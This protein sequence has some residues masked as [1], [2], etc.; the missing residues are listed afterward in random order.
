MDWLV[1][2]MSLP[3]RMMAQMGSATRVLHLTP[4]EYDRVMAMIGPKDD[5]IA[6]LLNNINLVLAGDLAPE[7][8]K[9]DLHHLLRLATVIGKVAETDPR[10]GLLLLSRF[11]RAWLD[12]DYINQGSLVNEGCAGR[13]LSRI[14][15]NTHAENT[16][17][18]PVT[19]EAEAKADRPR[20]NEKPTFRTINYEI[21][22]ALYPEDT[23]VSQPSS[24]NA[25][26]AKTVKTGSA[27]PPRWAPFP[28]FATT[29]VRAL[30]TVSVT[31]LR[32]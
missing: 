26:L 12:T 13:R 16:E 1:V 18:D 22:C 27:P 23:G 15:E 30:L 7:I 24:C 28:V 8:D 5:D 20:H 6:P 21:G 10:M 25:S 2:E 11:V 4:E 31:L 17:A 19:P 29:T 9:L 14:E 3:M 32:L